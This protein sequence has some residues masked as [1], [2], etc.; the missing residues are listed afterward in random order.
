ME[1]TQQI[2]VAKNYSDLIQGNYYRKI[3]IEEVAKSLNRAFIVGDWGM[4]KST[5][6][7]EIHQKFRIGVVIDFFSI[8]EKVS[9]KE[10]IEKIVQ[11]TL[12]DIESKSTNICFENIERLESSNKLKEILDLAYLYPNLSIYITTTID[13]LRKNENINELIG[14]E[15]LRLDE[16]DYLK[17]KIKEVIDTEY[18]EKHPID[19]EKALGRRKIWLAGHIWEDED[20]IPRFLNESVWINGKEKNDVDAV[21]ATKRGDIVFIKSTFAKAGVGHLRIKGIGIVFHNNYDGHNLK[22]NWSMFG[23]HI[24][25]PGLG[26]FRRTYQQLTTQHIYEVIS[27]ILERIPNFFELIENLEK[28]KRQKISGKIDEVLDDKADNILT[29]EG[30]ELDTEK[31]DPIIGFETTLEKKKRIDY[32]Y[33][34]AISTDQGDKDSLDFKKDV[35]SLAAL[36]AL[37]EMKP[38]LAIALFGQWGTGK[39]F[40]MNALE[41][42]IRELS[43]YQGFIKEH[44]SEVKNPV[45][46]QNELFHRGIA[47]IK[48]NAWSYLDANLWA[49]LAH[50]LF[51][52]LNLYITDNTKGDLERLKVQVIITKRLE[53]LHSDLINYED[54]KKQLEKLR[55]RLIEERDHWILRYFSSRYDRATKKFLESNGFDESEVELYT[56]SNLGKL[57][58]KGISLVKYLKYNTYQVTIILVSVVLSLL[59]AKGLILDL[60]SAIDNPFWKVLNSFW[61]SF[62]LTVLPILFIVVKF[63]LSKRKILSVIGVL[64]TDENRIKSSEELDGELSQV[65]EQTGEIN[66]LISAVEASIQKE[67]SS[68]SNLTELAI[69]NFI[70]MK[71]DQDDYK[72]HLGIITIIRKDF[73]TLS[74]LFADQERESNSTLNEKEKVRVEEL[75]SDRQEIAE[76]FDVDESPKLERIV[77]YID[78]L[79]R[80]TDDKVLEVLQAVHLLM[81]FPLFTV[82]VGVDE[83]CVHNALTY[84]QLKRY[85]NIDPL[86]ING[87]IEDIEPRN[88]LEK[89]FQIPFQLP[90]ATEKGV[91]QLIDDIIQKPVVGN[92]AE[93]GDVES[94]QIE[95]DDGLPEKPKSDG[96]LDQ[97][98]GINIESS[99]AVGEEHEEVQEEV[100]AVEPE[101]MRITNMEKRYLQLFVPLVGKNPRTV[102]RYVNIFRIVKTHEQNAVETVEDTVKVIF[103]LAMFIGDRREQAIEIFKTGQNDPVSFITNELD[104]KLH[105]FLD[106][107]RK[108]DNVIQEIMGLTPNSYTEVLQFIERFSYKIAIEKLIKLEDN[109]E[110]N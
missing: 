11:D 79:D 20:Q 9:L 106:D 30:K 17:D 82:L 56:P 27:K 37:K 3:Q 70:S 35:Q 5:L 7:K 19:I 86:L 85:R 94:D 102:K 31:E 53:I 48:F 52:K 16:S 67:Y 54:K 73:E 78:D 26:Q 23:D 90:I 18:S 109:D 50:S 6:V 59:I 40:F 88:Y 68:T 101:A 65:G 41:N 32:A 75:N 51:E 21:N 2:K 28:D 99:E 46:P 42:S 55:E 96:E 43:K 4:G 107:L 87:G 45:K 33:A 91:V 22:V 13:W 39:S 25:F 89:I 100:D 44:I 62:T 12:A 63:T 29:E 14:F 8:D 80:C 77:L 47:H 64:I 60:W 103:L 97:N 104:T 83:R 81:A 24:D 66:K 71:P 92:V 76:A 72:K 98:I 49:G 105:V 108:K 95:L 15:F 110:Q 57:I 10:L 69:G 84:Q 1:F 58:K 38:P 74:D 36:I 93:M 34:E 61:A